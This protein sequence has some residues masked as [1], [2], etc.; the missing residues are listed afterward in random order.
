[1]TDDVLYHYGTPQKYDGDP[2]GSGRY[3][4]GSGDNPYQHENDFMTQYNKLKEQ[5]LSEKEIAAG[6]GMTTTQLRAKKSIARAEIRRAN[7]ETVLKLQKEGYSNVEIGKILGINESTVRNLANTSIQERAEI[8]STTASMLKDNIDKQTYLDVGKGVEAYLGISRTKLKTA[9]EALKEE[10]YVTYDIKVEQLANPGQFTTVQVLAAPG[11]TIS[12]V[13]SAVKDGKLGSVINYSTD[14]GRTYLGLEP[15]TSVKSD[16]VMVRYAEEGGVDKDGVIELRRGVPELEM[17]NARYAQ[18]R[19]GVDGTHYLKGMAMYSDK[20]PDGVD[21][22]F[23]TNK[24]V[25][26][27]KEDVFKEMKDDPDNPFGATIKT[28][29]GQIVGQRHYIDKDGKEQ[30]SP[31]NI[32]NEEGDWG[33]WSKTLSSQVLSKQSTQLAKKQLNLA[34]SD[35]YEEYEEIMSLTN[36]AVKK[37]LLTAF[38]DD[39]DASA[40]DLHAAALPRQAS[41]VILPFPDMKENEIY[42]PKYNNGEQVV[43]IRHPHGGIFEIPELTVNNKNSSANKTIKNAIDAVGIN[44]KVAQQLSGADFDGDTVIVIPT[45]GV[46]IKTAPYLQELKD[47]DPKESYPGYPGMKKLEGQAKQTAMGDVSNLITDM[48]IKGAPLSEICMAVKHSMVVI[49]AEKHNLDWRQSAIDNNIKSLKTKYQGGA[50]R[51]ASTLISRASSEKRVPE[52]E[53][54]AYITTPDGKTKK[55]YIDP[56]TGEKLYSETGATY[57]NKAGK[58]VAKTTKTTKMAEV[59]DARILSSG[60]RMEEVYANYANKMKAL[61][62]EARKEVIS[63]KNT[64]YSPSAKQTYSKEVASLNAKLNEAIKNKPLERQA[65]ILANNVISVKKKDNP[66]LDAEHLKKLKSQALNEARNRVGA[67]KKSVQVNITPKEW[68]AIQAGAISNSKLSQILDNTDLDVV[69]Q[70]ATPRTTTQITSAKEA[71]IKAME[72]SGYTIKEIADAVGV[73]TS[74]V[75]NILH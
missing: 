28:E 30:L 14:G 62:N 5:G 43:L 35:K 32:V 38:A 16:R 60:T 18:V 61:G 59:S 42:A 57:I 4:K 25:G 11:S 63:T 17:G 10:G 8:T 2:H 29:N 15:P 21:I 72:A 48:T 75:S 34:Y 37:K 23:N 64:L 45:K 33:K 31:I 19:I 9:I 67:N 52:R 71:K 65:Q 68:E 70:Y 6:L 3:R 51:G 49:D 56:Q 50:N 27:P 13:Y 40:V 20:M 24:H 54:G 36:S 55:A 74:A 47:F 46:N 12:D 58:E 44:P 41:H 26:T 53:E 66:D 39:C 73:S 7:V 69:K 22:I 1:M